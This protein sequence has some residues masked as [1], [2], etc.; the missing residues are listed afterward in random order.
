MFG[1]CVYLCVSVD[2][3]AGVIC[4]HVNVV[5]CRY[6]GACVDIFCQCG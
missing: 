2:V 6:V 4:M 5:V 3:R 1:L